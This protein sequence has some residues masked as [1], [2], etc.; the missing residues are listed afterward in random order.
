MY[1]PPVTGGEIVP[2]VAK[3]AKLAK[4]A[5][6]EEDAVKAKL[7]EGAQD[8]PAF[9][10]AAEA[11]A[12]RVAI[13]QEILLRL[14][15]PLAVLAGVSREYFEH[16]FPAEMSERIAGTPEEH[17][18]SPRPS[19]AVPAIQ[20]LSYSLDEP[21]LKEMYLSLL[22]TATDNR[23]SEQAHPSFA[24]IIKQLSAPEARELLDVLRAR[25]LPVV[26]LQWIADPGRGSALMRNHVLPYSAVQG[27]PPSENPSLSV[28]VDN[29]VRLGLVH[30]DYTM[31]LTADGAYD[32]VQE[33]PEYIDLASRHL[34]GAE[35]IEITR[36]IMRSTDFGSRFA[37][38]VSTVPVSGPPA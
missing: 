28:W 38:A 24:E 8:T 4:G 22:A 25:A 29:W 17:L 15:L 9:Q 27:G 21:D 36:G 14:F 13:K 18:T 16:D 31:H 33:R 10:A 35:G 1:G 37:Q 19:V 20:G 11:Y 5:L 12:R 34:S 30:A 3:A 23:V 2:A 26:R 32:F 7:L 6:S